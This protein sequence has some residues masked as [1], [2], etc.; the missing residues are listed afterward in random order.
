MKREKKIFKDK[1][2]MLRKGIQKFE[3]E[4]NM[5]ERSKTLQH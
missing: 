1:A 3:F 4:I 5:K 2:R